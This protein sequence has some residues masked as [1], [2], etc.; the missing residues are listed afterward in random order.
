MGAGKSKATA[1]AE[2]LNNT[3]LSIATSTVQN[4]SAVATQ[5]QLINLR[6][7][8]GTIDMRNVNI[9]QGSTI[10]LKCALSANNKQNMI[11]N[12]SSMLSNT[13]AASASTAGGNSKS[14]SSGKITNSVSGAVNNL[15]EQNLTA[16]ISQRQ[17]VDASNN[18]GLI[19]MKGST[20][21]QSAAIVA[22]GI[23]DAITA[24]GI[25]SEVANAIT[26]TS[27]SKSNNPI[28]SIMGGLGKYATYIII[29][30]VIVALVVGGILLWPSIRSAMKD[31]PEDS[32]ISIV[33][34]QDRSEPQ[35]TFE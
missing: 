30:I 28:D 34:V 27:D 16:I 26:N 15:T 25:T 32:E 33:T 9:T 4:C 12:I 24:T 35:Y 6:G 19:L 31:D 18:S 29:F 8:T 1:A 3:M 10:N 5:D 21:G 2:T 17:S 14:V 23:V 11:A 22:Q 7:N 20:I 13:A